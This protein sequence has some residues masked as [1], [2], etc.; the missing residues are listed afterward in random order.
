MSGAPEPDP[1]APDRA[2]PHDGLVAASLRAELPGLGVV[3]LALPAPRAKRSPKGVRE[4]LAV[5]S[6]RFRGGD[7]LALRQRPVPHAYRV[8]FR[9]VGLDPDVTRTPV[10]AAAIER[11]VQGGFVSRGL[12]DDALTIA[13]VETGVPLWALDA[14]AVDGALQLRLARN[15]E[16]LGAGAGALPLPDGQIVVADA[17]APLASL[18]GDPTPARTPARATTRLLLYA[19]RVDG[20]DRVHVEEALWQCAETLAAA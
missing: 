1:R 8:A 10:E 12:L 13:L 5:L 19:L 17:R 2:G 6:T 3:S 11:L 18:F 7:A 16:Q 20:V 14:D 4:H 15:G 9:H